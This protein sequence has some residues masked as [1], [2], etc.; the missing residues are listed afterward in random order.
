MAVFDTDDM[1]TIAQLAEELRVTDATARGIVAD[2]EPVIRIGRA[3]F[4]S[5]DDIKSI[6][7]ER[8]KFMLLFIDVRPEAESYDSIILGD[9]SASGE[10]R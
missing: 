10:E 2:L 1:V 9:D 5:R 8:H 3:G 7:R 4:Y 6:F